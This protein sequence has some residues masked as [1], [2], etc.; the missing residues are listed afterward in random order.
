[1]VA[2]IIK[3]PFGTLLESN[4]LKLKNNFQV[5]GLKNLFDMT[6]FKNWIQD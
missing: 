3:G 4:F 1:M 6:I 2:Q 5:L